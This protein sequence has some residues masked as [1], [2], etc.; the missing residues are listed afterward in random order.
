MDNRGIISMRTFLN[1]RVG[2]ALVRTL[3]DPTV[4]VIVKVN[5]RF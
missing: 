5:M 1:V 2:V 4:V 3:A